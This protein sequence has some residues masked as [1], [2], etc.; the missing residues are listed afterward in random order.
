MLTCFYIL[1]RRKQKFVHSSENF[2]SRI[3]SSFNDVGLIKQG[4]SIKIDSDL[5]DN[6]SG[7]VQPKL[8]SMKDPDVLCVYYELPCISHVC[9]LDQ[10]SLKRYAISS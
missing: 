6:I 2:A 3:I 9:S 1:K 10:H 8:E 4:N 5:S 7:F